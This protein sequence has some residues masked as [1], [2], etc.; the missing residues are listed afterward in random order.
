MTTEF[1]T[2]DVPR[3]VAVPPENLF[4]C[5]TDPDLKARWFAGGNGPDWTT[6]HYALDPSEGGEEF[7][8][9]KHDKM[10]AIT[11]RARLIEIRAPARLIYS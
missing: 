8:R 11:Y 3:R 9:F 5:W 4:R 6:L 10:G 7:A 1:Q 2:F